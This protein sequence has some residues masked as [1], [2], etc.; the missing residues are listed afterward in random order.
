MTL[1]QLFIVRVEY[2]DAFGRSKMCLRKDLPEMKKKDEKV[3]MKSSE[4]RL[5]F[6]LLFENWNYYNKK[7]Q[8]FLFFKANLPCCLMI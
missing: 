2:V 5:A 1:R 4:E 8:V 6:S 3:K 7:V